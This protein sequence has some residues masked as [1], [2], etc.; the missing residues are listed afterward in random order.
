MPVPYTFANATTAIP[1]SQLDSNFGTA[2]TLGNTAIQLGNTVTTLNNMSL[3]NVT[4]SSGNVTITNVTVTTADVSDEYV[5]SAALVAVTVHVPADDA[6]RSE[7][8]TVHPAVPAETTAYEYEPDPDP[9]EA[10]SGTGV[11]AVPAE[12]LSVTADWDSRETVTVV[13]D[14]DSWL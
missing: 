2:I 11:P 6:L 7:P 1:L 8:D 3:A 9:P 14:E 12:A 4:I 13:A 5:E 10:M